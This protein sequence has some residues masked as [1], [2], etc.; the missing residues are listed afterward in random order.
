MRRITGRSNI[1]RMNTNPEE[2]TVQCRESIE[3]PKVGARVVAWR[4][5]CGNRTR[6]PSGLCHVHRDDG[7]YLGKRSEEG[8]R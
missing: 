1:P 7:W 4:R 6:H 5:P 2:Q 3:G 8:G